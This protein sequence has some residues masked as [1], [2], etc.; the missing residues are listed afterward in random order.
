MGKC[1]DRKNKEIFKQRVKIG[2][3]MANEAKILHYHHCSV[4]EC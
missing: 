1:L 3:N 2:Y 4:C